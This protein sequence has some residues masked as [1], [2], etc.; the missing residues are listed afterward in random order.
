MGPFFVG[1]S[2]LITSLVIICDPSNL[3][4]SGSQGTSHESDTASPSHILFLKLK[5]CWLTFDEEVGVGVKRL[6][7]QCAGC[8]NHIT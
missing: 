8:L 5:Y 3:L 1:L 4:D 6:T 2:L 7:S